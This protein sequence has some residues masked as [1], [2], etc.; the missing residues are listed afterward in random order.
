MAVP[1]T[2]I[3]RSL[4]E[5]EY[6]EA[7]RLQRALTDQRSDTSADEIWLLSHP[8][9]FTLG[10]AGKR[11][12]ILDPGNIDIVQSDRGGQV[13]YHG[14]GQLVVYT[15]FDLRRHNL[16]VRALVTQLESVVIALLA[17]HG[18]DAEADPQA[19]GVYVSGAKIAA[20]GLRIRRGCSY[21]GL[22]LNVSLD[23]SVY[24][25]INPCG[26]PDLSVTRTR[27]HGILVDEWTLGELIAE[28]LS[29]TLGVARIERQDHLPVLAN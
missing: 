15:L 2:L 22:S 20:L 16:G 29:A 13:T 11:E 19:P 17:D 24:D 4:G 27:D 9:V 7:Q 14:P 1:G 12:H 28:R 26:Y 23:L 25:R 5:V 3:L 21:H 10:Q 6:P 8:P 18:V